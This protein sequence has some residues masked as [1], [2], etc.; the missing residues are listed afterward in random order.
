MKVY[1][2]NG[3]RI[4]CSDCVKKAVICIDCNKSKINFCEK[5]F[6]EFVNQVF[7]CADEAFFD[8]ACKQ[9]V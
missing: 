8:Q 4:R 7:Q 1:L 5:H 6:T 3:G 9:A 2:N